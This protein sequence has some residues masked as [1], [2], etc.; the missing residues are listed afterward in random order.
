M[1]VSADRRPT[2]PQRYAVGMFGTSI[3]INM[4][5]G[6]MFLFYIDILGL[7]V[8]IYGSVMLVYAIIDAIDNPVL[9]YFSDRTRTRYGRRRPWLLIGAPLLTAGF[10]GFFSAPDTLEGMQL[11]I[12]FTV[13]AILTEA[14]DSMLNVNYGALLPELFP[15][16]RQRA[17]ANAMRQGFQLLALVISL[18]LTPWLTTSVFGTEESTEGF[19]TTALIYAAVAVVAILFMALGIREDTRVVER[20]R[21][22]LRATIKVIVANPKFWQ[23]GL[24][25]ACYLAAMG[26]VLTGVQLYVRYTLGRSVAD[27]MY[28]Q[29][30]VILCCVAALV[31]WARVVRRAGAPTVWR[32]GFCVILAGF[33]ALYFATGLWGAIAAGIVLGIGYSAMLASNDLVIARVLDEDA[34]RHGERREG[35]FLAAFGFF[36]RLSGVVS[37]GALASLGF[38]FGYHSGDD[39]GTQADT[40]WRVYLTVYPA[41]L[42][43]IGALLA[44]RIQVPDNRRGD[45]DEAIDPFEALGE[46][47]ADSGD[48][49]GVGPEIDRRG[50]SSGRPD[51]DS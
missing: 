30:V 29:G 42:A 22:R 12:W 46:P 1:S 9:A 26:L 5:K 39:P 34:A 17:L 8:V 41:I 19:T 13:F 40:A 16:E 31:V 21:P 49:S 10:I 37:A 27:A 25:S 4:I 28:L 33:I 7:D 48:D 51:R 47:P 20:P 6:S 36:G 3:P 35:M 24:A 2:S 15:R 23:I 11:V 38:L 18:A 45:E 32:I 43:A 44:W 14:A 50:L